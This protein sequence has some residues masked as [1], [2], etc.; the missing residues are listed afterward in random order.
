MCCLTFCV[1]VLCHV[2]CSFVSAGADALPI[3]DE[4]PDAVLLRRVV[5]PQTNFAFVNFIRPLVTSDE[6]DDDLDRPLYMTFSYG[7]FLVNS[8]LPIGP[9]NGTIWL[10]GNPIQFDC[11]STCKSTL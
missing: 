8:P 4:E 1:L 3:Q 2:R 5:D 9:P 6:S 11:S 7:P 10:S